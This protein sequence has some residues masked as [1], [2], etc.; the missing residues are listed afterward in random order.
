MISA[1][2]VMLKGKSYFKKSAGDEAGCAPKKGFI[3]GQNTGKVY[4]KAWSM[5]VLIE[6]ENVVRH[7]DLTTHNHA[8]DIGNESSPWPQVER[9]VMP[10]KRKKPCESNCPKKPSDARA[11]ELRAKTPSA[12]AQAKVNKGKK[13]LTCATCKKKFPSLAADHIVPLKRISRMPGF[14]CLPPEKQEQLINSDWNFVGIC[15]SC[16]SSKCAK[17]WHQWSGVKSKNIVFDKELIQSART[18]TTDI[19]VNFFVTIQKAKCA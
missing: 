3:N 14:A 4:F 10:K 6:G 15:N 11:K 5:D 12:S 18:L 9:M 8:S 16:N 1:A 2:E 7:L 19:F 17:L 13:P